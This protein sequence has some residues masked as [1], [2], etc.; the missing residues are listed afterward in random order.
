[1]RVGWGLKTS[2][3]SLAPSRAV[4]PA[5]FSVVLS[6]S[7][8]ESSEVLVRLMLGPASWLLWTEAL[9]QCELSPLS[10]APL[11]FSIWCFFP[12]CS[13]EEQILADP[14]KIWLDNRKC[15]RS[16]A[17][18]TPFFFFF[19]NPR[20]CKLERLLSLCCVPVCVWILEH[21]GLGYLW[22][23]NAHLSCLRLFKNV[24]FSW[25]VLLAGSFIFYW[26][27]VSGVFFLQFSCFSTIVKKYINE[28]SEINN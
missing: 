6:M 21:E 22:C 2:S 25:L 24:R 17:N 8:P 26:F 10:S 12:R 9:L 20:L 27:G 4:S 28:I 11:P 13:L 15:H 18:F 23:N 16:T 14:Q 5:P 19:L 3:I 7:R 1:M